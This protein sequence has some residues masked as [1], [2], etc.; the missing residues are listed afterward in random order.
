M[1]RCNV[2]PKKWKLYEYSNFLG[3]YDIVVIAHN[4]KC[5]DRL[6]S[7][8]GIQYCGLMKALLKPYLG[9]CISYC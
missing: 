4:G 2:N 8:S 3:D 7:T 9:A 5:A 6:L 1:E